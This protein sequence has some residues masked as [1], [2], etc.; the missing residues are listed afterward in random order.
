MNRKNFE[1][2]VGKPVDL[3]LIPNIEY[4]SGTVNKCEDDYIV[5]GDELWSYQAILG[6][7]PQAKPSPRKNEAQKK[8]VPEA[9][10]NVPEVIDTPQKEKEVDVKDFEG[11]EFSGTLVSFFYERGMWGFI[12]SEEVKSCGVKLRDGEKVF[13]HIKQVSDQA[14]QQKLINE[15]K[16]N[17][18][19]EVV[20][21]LAQNS[22]GVAADD[23][24]EKNPENVLKIDMAEALYEEGEIEFFRRYEEIPHGEIRV[25]GNKLYRFDETDVVDPYLAVF[26]ECSPSA[27][28]QP[29]KFMKTVGKR[30]Q[31]KAVNVSALGEFPEDKVQEWEK[32]GLLE[33]AKQ[34]LGIQ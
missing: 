7:R 8:N 10:K 23:V 34:R 22:Q 2:F 9:V 19:I 12:E 33:K 15:R 3:F 18:N 24:R 26:L 16:P 6:I 20:F 27:E 14:L 28:G 4:I 5:I 13:V 25:K 30:G 29:V 17:P 11:R 1:P 21:K 31:T 32:S